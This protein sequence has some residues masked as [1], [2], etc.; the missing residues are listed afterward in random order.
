MNFDYKRLIKFELNIS[1]KE[2]TIRMG[3]GGALILVSLFLAKVLL[4]LVGLI[5]ITSG[6]IGWCPAYSA[7]HKN[8]RPASEND[9]SSTE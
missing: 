1:N 9:E 5:L 8:T 2:K 7:F 6:Y 3:V 4:L